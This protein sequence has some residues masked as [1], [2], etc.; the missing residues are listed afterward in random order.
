MVGIVLLGP[1]G[2]GKGTQA[3][4]LKEA[5]GLLHFSTGDALRQAVRS[6]SALGLRVKSVMDSG[7]LVSDELVG[8][9][10][11]CALAEGAASCSGFLLDG[12]PRTPRQIEILDGILATRRLP[13]DHAILI[14]APEAVLLRRLTGRRVCPCCDAVYNLGGRP[15]KTAGRCDACGAALVQRPD[16]GSETVLERLRVYRGQ[17]APV[18][19]IYKD[20]SLLREIDGS[21]E[22]DEVF[23]SILALLRGVVV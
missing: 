23:A 19:A 15:P 9:V 5:L 11:E 2:V 7:S 6:G 22:S 17:T 1:P 20:R 10:V 4:R 3:V 8:E 14:D 12:F 21:R 18:I 16:D 13:L